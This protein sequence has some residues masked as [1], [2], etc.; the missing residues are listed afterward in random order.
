MIRLRAPH[1]DQV[2][3]ARWEERGV[4]MAEVLRQ[5]TRH[6][7]QLARHDA[8]DEDMPHPRNCC[9]NLVTVAEGKAQV[10]LAERVGHALAAHHPLR[11]LVIELD[12]AH[13]VERIDAWLLTEAHPTADGMPVQFERVRLRVSGP[14]IDA[15]ESLVGPLLVPEVPTCLW[16]L[17]TPPFPDPAFQR[18]L[19]LSD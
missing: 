10:G 13:D 9:L 18:A 11:Q 2:R 8:R 4:T 16:W 12:P 6:H 7:A 5:V 3:S 17:G 14:G 15:I 1:P 19:D